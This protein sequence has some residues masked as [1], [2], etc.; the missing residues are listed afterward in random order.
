MNFTIEVNRS[1]SKIIYFPKVFIVPVIH[2]TGKT[3]G[4]KLIEILKIFVSLSFDTSGS[5]CSHEYECIFCE[6]KNVAKNSAIYN[7]HVCNI[8]PCC[9][10]E[11]IVLLSHKTPWNIIWVWLETHSGI[12]FTCIF[13]W[14]YRLNWTKTSWPWLCF[15]FNFN[16]WNMVPLLNIMVCLY[17]NIAGYHVLPC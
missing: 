13:L 14:L 17:V 11:K 16:S 12:L 6:W 9:W 5:D 10:S 1:N 15:S 4:A 3:F 8:M 7:L 2:T